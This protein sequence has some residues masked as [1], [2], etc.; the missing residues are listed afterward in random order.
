MAQKVLLESREGG[1]EEGYLEEL[2]LGLGIDGDTELE[3]SERGSVVYR[4]I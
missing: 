3:W 2:G 1:G 4:G